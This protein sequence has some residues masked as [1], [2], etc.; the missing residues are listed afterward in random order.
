M[1]FYEGT[2]GRECFRMFP[3]KSIWEELSV[4]ERREFVV[5]TN[6]IMDYTDFQLF[7]PSDCNSSTVTGCIMKAK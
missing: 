4:C 7:L 5:T 6:S 1:E 2:D 3:G